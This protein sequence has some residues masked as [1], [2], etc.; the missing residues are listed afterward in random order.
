MFACSGIIIILLLFIGYQ[1]YQ[2]INSV[3][4]IIEYV[5]TYKTDLD[6]SKEY[7]IYPLEREKEFDPYDWSEGLLPFSIEI[8]SPDGLGA[9][10]CPK[11]KDNLH[12]TIYPDIP[13]VE[14][15]CEDD[16]IS[17]ETH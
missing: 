14:L 4:N 15:K 2:K 13:G 7:E 3:I 5:S 12:L 17:F 11:M 10:I 6:L 8:L 9:G 1:N 16:R